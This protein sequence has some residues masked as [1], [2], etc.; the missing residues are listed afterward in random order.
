[1]CPSPYNNLGYS[2]IAVSPDG[3]TVVVGDPF[4][5]LVAL[6]AHSGVVLSRVQ[7]HAQA[8]SALEYSPDGDRLFSAS[9][10]GTFLL[11]LN[12]ESEMQEFFL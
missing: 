2:S 11:H 6:N 9:H 7:A 8:I 3:N 12:G 10:D 4:G 5:R 1:M